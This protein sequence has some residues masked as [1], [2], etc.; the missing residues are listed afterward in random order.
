MIA[1]NDPHQGQP[2]PAKASRHTAATA[3][4]IEQT[5]ER[6]E[7]PLII[8][9]IAKRRIETDSGIGDTLERIFARFG[10]RQFKAVMDR[11]KINCGCDDRKAA[12]NKWF[13]YA[14][15]PERAAKV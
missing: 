12:L 14:D 4:G 8:R 7:W 6:G 11:L 2:T 13:R 10:G 3:G 15:D 9:M 5:V 1:F